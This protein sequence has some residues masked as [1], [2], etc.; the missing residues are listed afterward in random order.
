MKN[1]ILILITCMFLIS[2]VSASQS[3]LPNPIQEG[4][5]ASL[6]Q[7]C[8]DC[9]YVNIT[10]I[11]YPNSTTQNINEVMIKNGVDYTYSFCNTSALGNY[12]YNTCGDKGGSLTCEEIN[13]EVTPTGE[14][15]TEAKSNL[16]IISFIILIISTIF[17]LVLGLFAKN[18]P[19]KIFF[20]G[21]SIVF[22]VATLGFSVSVWQQIFGSFGN[23]VETYGRIFILLTILLTGGGISLFVYLVYMAI[24]S[25]WK[26]SRGMV[27]DDDF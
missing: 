16:L 2:L 17:L 5:C 10:S 19:F 23:L 3:S 27:D 1:K 4:E 14:E 12:I 18:T 20:I 13:F 22:M 7:I 21:L 11:T 25:F 26:N 8:D 9:T 15:F 6:Y 24:M